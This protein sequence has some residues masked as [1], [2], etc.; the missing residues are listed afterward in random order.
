MMGTSV[1]KSPPVVDRE[2]APESASPETARPRTIITR[3]IFRD[4]REAL[5]HLT[6]WVLA[7]L[8][9]YGLGVIAWLILL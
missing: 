2:P 3:A 8:A 1:A 4:W 7:G 9:V 6:L 5:R